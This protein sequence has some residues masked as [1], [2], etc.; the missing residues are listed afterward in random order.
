MQEAARSRYVI[1]FIRR[2]IQFKCD[3]ASVKD[4]CLNIR[5]IVL[6]LGRIRLTEKL[7]NVV[8]EYGS[9]F[10]LVCETIYKCLACITFLNGLSLSSMLRMFTPF[11]IMMVLNWRALLPVM[12]H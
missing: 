1:G 3:E 7:F 8:R 4:L 10:D 5:D 6:V 9:E 12:Q 2:I 11:A